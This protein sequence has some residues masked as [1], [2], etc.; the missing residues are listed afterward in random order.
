MAN[1][2]YTRRLLGLGLTTCLLAGCTASPGNPFAFSSSGHTLIDSAMALRA[3]AT[4]PAP[5][6]RELDKRVTPPYLVEP[7]DVLLVQAADLESP[8]RLPGDQP[9]LQDGTITLGRYGR[10]TV[11]GKT[12]EQIEAEAKAAVEAQTPK[13]GP[14]TVRIVSRPSKVYYVLGDVNAPGAFPYTGRETVLDGLVAAGGLTERASRKN[15]LLS[16]PTRP[17]G[18]RIVLPVCYQEIVQLGDTSTN[19]QLSPGDRIYVPSKTFW[20]ELL[21]SKKECPPCGGAQV[22]CGF[23]GGSCGAPAGPDGSALNGH[24]PTYV[25]P[26][27]VETLPGSPKLLDPQTSPLEVPGFQHL[28]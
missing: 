21:H 28:P 25:A 12:A 4:E 11:A 24:V 15:V 6:P 8:A 26:P 27:G 20:E 18:C 9:V 2:G 5:L 14:I 10:L 13:A 19:Y 1:P 22:P 7:G 17:D 3:A 23:G 16:R